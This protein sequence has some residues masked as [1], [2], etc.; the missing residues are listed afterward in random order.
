MR[1]RSFLW[2]PLFCALSLFGCGD[3]GEPKGTVGRSCEVDTDCGEE[4]VAYCGRGFTQLAGDDTPDDSTDA[5]GA[6]GLLMPPDTGYC[7]QTAGCLNDSECPNGSACYRPLVDVDPASVGFA[8]ADLEAGHCL[9]PCTDSSDC[10]AD[11]G[12]VCGVPLEHELAGVAG[13]DQSAT[14]C[15]PEPLGDPCA[16]NPAW[17]TAG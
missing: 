16:P 14:F 12:F 6:V 2:A 13:V 10:R 8:T 4:G 7:M 1:C 17:N 3:D 11:E 15:I 5:L 9:V